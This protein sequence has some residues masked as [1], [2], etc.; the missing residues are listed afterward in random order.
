M[1]PL[2]DVIVDEPKAARQ[3]RAFAFGQ[4]ITRIFGFIA[5]NKFPID[6]SLSS[7]ARSVP[8]TRGSLAGRKPT[9]G[10]HQQLGM[11]PFGAVGLHK[12]VKIAVKPALTDFGMD[13]VGDLAPQLQWLVESPCRVL[14]RRAI[15]CAPSHYLRMNKVLRPA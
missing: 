9:R 1:A 2:Q 3:K 12:A 13:L 5:Q 8:W 6:R 15:E 10:H 4:A 11:A 14:I 7:I